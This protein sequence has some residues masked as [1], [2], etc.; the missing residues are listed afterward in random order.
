MYYILEHI[1]KWDFIF[2]KTLQMIISSVLISTMPLSF[3]PLDKWKIDA[4]I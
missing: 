2:L 1:L 3:F 4:N